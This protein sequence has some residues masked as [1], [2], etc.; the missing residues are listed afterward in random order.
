MPNEINTQNARQYTQLALFSL[1]FYSAIYLFNRLVTHYPGNNYIYYPFVG[2]FFSLALIHKG[3]SILF[4]ETHP[5]RAGIQSSFFYSMVVLLMQIAC[6]AVQYTPFPPIDT[7]I[8]SLERLVGIDLRDILHWTMNAP[9]WVQATADM[10]YNI[11]TREIL[12][13]P[14][15][16]I[17]LKQYHVV[18]RLSYLLL[19]SAFIGL[20]IYYIFP[21]VGPATTL[22]D[23]LFIKDQYA[24]GLKFW[25]IHHGIAPTT[26][27]GGLIAFPSFHVIWAF[28][29][30]LAFRPWPIAFMLMIAINACMIISCILLGWH[31]VTDVIGSILVVIVTYHLYHTQQTRQTWR[32]LLPRMTI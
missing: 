21:T 27:D 7:H 32:F 18:N 8:V 12:L 25:Q 26:S 24:T 20:L 22:Q 23:P 11:L 16:L 29:Y 10:F 1:I 15:L 19:I 4:P 28:L 30:A 3:C 14:L 13:L 6:T 17:V 9:A 5:L 2:A 31:Y